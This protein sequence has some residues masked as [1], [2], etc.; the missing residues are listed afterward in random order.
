MKTSSTSSRSA[1]ASPR[2]TSAA[3]HLLDHGAVDGRAS[4]TAACWRRARPTSPDPESI[5]HAALGLA[6]DERGEASEQ[7][8]LSS[9]AICFSRASMR[10]AGM[11]QKSWRW[12]RERMVSG[13]LWGS[14]V[15]KMNFTCPGGS[16]RVLRSALNAAPSHVDLVDD[17]DLVARSR[18]G[19]YLAFS[20][21]SRTFSTP[22][23]EA[24]SI[25]AT[26]TEVPAAISVRGSHTEGV[27]VGPWMQLRAGGRRAA[28]VLPTP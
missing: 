11:R 6:D 13:N 27:A 19:R 15:A 16:S 12:R 7:P 5:A 17:V 9:A 28:V 20:R 3:S 2:R 22:L 1:F 10:S 21:I 8:G 24:P 18:W 14:V 25:S 4:A 26:S 23:L